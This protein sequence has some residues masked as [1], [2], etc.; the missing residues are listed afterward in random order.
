MLLARRKMFRLGLAV[1]DTVTLVSAFFVMFVT[2]GPSLEQEYLAFTKYTSLLISIPAIWLPC[3]SFFGLYRSTTY[4]STRQALMAVLHVQPV[5]IVLLLGLLYLS[6]LG[7]IGHVVLPRFF[8]LSSILVAIQ[9]LCAVWYLGHVF[10]RANVHR[11]KVVLVS[12]RSNAQRLLEIIRA[13]FSMLADVVQVLTPERLENPGPGCD[14]SDSWGAIDDLPA[15]LN[16]KVIDEVIAVLPI[17]Q[18][19]LDRISRWCAIRGVLLRVWLKLPSSPIG[20]WGAEYFGDGAFLVSLAAVPQSLGLVMLKRIVDV[21]GAAIGIIICGIV[22]LAYG[23]RL[24][25]ESG[26]S[27]IF[28]QERVGRNGRTFTLYKFRTMFA[29]A[30]QQKS[31][32]SERNQMQGPIFKLRNDPRVTITGRKLRRRHL[33]ELPQFWNVLRG[34]M[35]LVGTRP[36]TPDETAVY[37]DHHHRRLSIKPGITGLWQVN[38]NGVVKDF[39]EVVRLDCE[40]IDRCSLWLDAWIL[41]KTVKKVFRG[42]GW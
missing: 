26:G 3:F 11:R 17:D 34:E 18:D 32:I 10:N 30:E 21:V 37:Q 2:A 22:Y 33:D 38:G 16:A 8:V 5:A 39:E 31:V 23:L 27:S 14:P 13:R 24:Q 41:S 42:D 1:I 28:C 6:G 15:L 9:K 29:E 35:S 40:Y 19:V 12:D 36:P 25:R 7:S 20:D 4:G